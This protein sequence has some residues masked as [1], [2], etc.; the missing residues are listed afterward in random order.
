MRSLSSCIG[1][2]MSHAGRLRPLAKVV[3][4]RNRVM[5]RGVLYVRGVPSDGGAVSGVARARICCLRRRR[6]S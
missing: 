5:R 3:E 4:S 1:E 6:L 2:G